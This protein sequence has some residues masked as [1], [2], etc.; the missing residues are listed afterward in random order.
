[1]DDEP[2]LPDW[3]IE[4]LE[5]PVAMGEGRNNQMIR[6]GPT[7]L[8]YGMDPEALEEKFAEM[9]PDIGPQQEREIAAVVKNSVKLAAREQS[10]IDKTQ[11]G[12][13]KLELS[14]MQLEARQALPMILD[15]YQWPIAQIRSDGAVLA[16]L[17]GQPV[18]VQRRL[19]LECMFEPD[20]VVWIGAVWETGKPKHKGRF[21]Q[22]RSWL[23]FHRISGEFCSHCTF[24]PGSF[25]RCNENVE[26]RKYLVVES[27][28]LTPDEVGAV[29][30]Y[31]ASEQ[32]L[33]LRAIV[34]TGG[35]SLHGWFNW[36]GDDFLDEWSAKLMG[37]KC[38][39]S[40][41]RPSQPVRLP[42]IIRAKTRRPQELLYLI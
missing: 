34:S 15:H 16:S 32:G 2:K 30:N 7:M 5:N 10:E 29:F 40:T 4:E 26:S 41:M 21:L 31:L 1:M 11:Y 28:V 19:F 20:D 8:R 13:R 12:K 6:I 37:W 39:P 23:D 24:L 27:D 14:R 18:S 3:V 9:Y 36:P 35:K 17:D 42:G 38:D 25:S 33:E 22:I